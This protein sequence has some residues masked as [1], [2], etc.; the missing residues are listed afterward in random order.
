VRTIDPVKHE[1]K[2]AEILEAAERCFARDGFHGATIAQIC[3]EAKISPGHLYHYFAS[4]EAIVSAIVDAGVEGTASR[5]AELMESSNAITALVSELARLRALHR[6]SG[7]GVHL[8]VLAE[9]GRSPAIGPV[10]QESTKGV[11]KLLADLLRKGQSR[12]QIDPELDVDMTAA[13]LISVNDGSKSL[14]IRDP[15]LDAKKSAKTF[16]AMIT[17]FL[18]PR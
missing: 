8:D 4:K 9:A 16:E 13:V 15:K 6:K 1:E 11:R 3:A 2:R 7:A 5:F 12:G 17:R 14:L 18:S 10:I